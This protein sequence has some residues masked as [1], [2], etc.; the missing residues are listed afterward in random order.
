MK[1]MTKDTFTG[2]LY[3]RILYVLKMLDFVILSVIAKPQYY[4]LKFSSL[5]VIQKIC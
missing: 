1:C 3:I 2:T 5:C 4:L